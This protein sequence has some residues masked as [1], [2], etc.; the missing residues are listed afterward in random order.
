MSKG[1]LWLI[2]SRSHANQVPL[3]SFLLLVMKILVSYFVSLL[4][5]IG[6]GPVI[7]VTVNV[8]ML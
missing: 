8:L 4:T 6:D 3:A 7:T 2:L 5:C 1:K